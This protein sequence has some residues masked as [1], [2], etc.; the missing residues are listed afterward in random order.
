MTLIL[1]MN[2][3]TYIYFSATSTTS[4]CAKA[5]GKATGLPVNREINIAD[6]HATEL[7]FI[8][9]DDVAIIAAPVYSGRLPQPAVDTIKRLKGKGASV[10]AIV[11]YGNRDYDDALL[12]LTD[13]L[14]KTGFNIIGAGAFIGQHSIFPKVGTNRP[15]KSDLAVL[16]EFGKACRKRLDAGKPYDDIETKG[17]NPY[18]TPMS[19][20]LHPKCD[21]HNCNRCSECA[22]K[23]PVGAIDK[24]NPVETDTA[25]CISCGRCIYVCPR[26]A[27]NYS[28]IKYT[29]IGKVFIS[30][31]SKRKE[32]EW[33][34]AD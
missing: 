10:I 15:D 1:T 34:V 13:M 16:D 6:N 14:K 29:L 4:K 26:N 23:C 21:S 31:Y 27:R 24:D 32:P 3:L 7:P 11:V 25:K 5:I 18:K 19:V 2:G 8:E 17:N 33:K 9:S 30:S 12:E 20:P 22:I 28:G